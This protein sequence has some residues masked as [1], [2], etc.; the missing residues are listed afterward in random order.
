MSEA[1]SSTSKGALAS[2]S[3]GAVPIRPCVAATVDGC[4]G[5]AVSGLVGSRSVR[6]GLD[7]VSGAWKT[8]SGG[9]KDWTNRMNSA[10]GSS[11]ACGSPGARTR[12]SNSSMLIVVDAGVRETLISYSS[13][14]LLT[15]IASAPPLTRKIVI[16]EAKPRRAPPEKTAGGGAISTERRPNPDEKFIAAANTAPAAVRPAEVF[17]TARF[18]RS[19]LKVCKNRRRREWAR[20]KLASTRVAMTF[21]HSAMVYSRSGAS[22][23]AL[24]HRQ[25]SQSRRHECRLHL[26]RDV[27]RLS[28]RQGEDHLMERFAFEAARGPRRAAQCHHQSGPPVLYM[29]GLAMGQN[30]P[31]LKAPIDAVGEHRN[32]IVTL[33]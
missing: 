20:K 23:Q 17:A 24:R 27:D 25:G 10:R 29:L 13:K 4:S 32:D 7:R 8:P 18:C 14:T 9:P 21:R 28:L 16:S 5:V 30:S 12:R 19:V 11:A 6:P 2:T 22:R 33:L 3:G 1:Q 15:R 31:D 26:L